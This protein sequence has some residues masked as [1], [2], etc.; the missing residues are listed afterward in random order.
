MLAGVPRKGGRPPKISSYGNMRADVQ[1]GHARYQFNMDSKPVVTEAGVHLPGYRGRE[2]D[3]KADLTHDG[4]AVTIKFPIE[5]GRSPKVA[6]ALVK[7]AAE[8]LC[9]ARGRDCA[10]QVLDGEITNYVVNGHGYRPVILFGAD[11]GR[12]EHRFEHIGMVDGSGWYCCFRLAHF[13]VM[14]DLTESPRLSWRPVGLSYATAATAGSAS[15]R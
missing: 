8:Y 1:T 14:V 10:A 7:L 9:W 11:M 6:R 5:F 13:N 3:I 12:Y 2:R 15:C 4:D